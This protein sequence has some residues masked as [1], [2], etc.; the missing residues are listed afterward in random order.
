MGSRQGFL[1]TGFRVHQFEE[2][3]F[4][5]CQSSWTLVAMRVDVTRRGGFAGVVLHATLDTAQLTAADALRAEAAL[6]GLP[7]DRPPAEPTGA[8]RFRYAMVTV[9][10][11]RERHVELSETEISDALRPL[12]ELLSDQG[13]LR[14]ASG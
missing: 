11:G 14:A 1:V 4:R 10:G 2:N 5:C 3:R 13:Q 6:R 8:D 7:W 9:D 12:L